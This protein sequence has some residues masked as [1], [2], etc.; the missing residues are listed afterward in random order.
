MGCSAISLPG[1][2]GTMAQQPGT[3][4]WEKGKI[5]THLSFQ[6][7]VKKW[8]MHKQD[9]NQSCHSLQKVVEGEDIFSTRRNKNKN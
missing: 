4:E 7:E 3:L 1:P 9:I 2:G 5:H 8:E 6:G